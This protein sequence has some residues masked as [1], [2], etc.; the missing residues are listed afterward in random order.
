MRDM[1]NFVNLK[2]LGQ[3]T[4]WIEHVGMRKIHALK[5]YMEVES[6]KFN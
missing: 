3:V 5:A 4:V 6:S 1:Q 2:T